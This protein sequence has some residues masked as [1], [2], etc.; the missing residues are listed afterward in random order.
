MIDKVD[1]LI[2][3]TMRRLDPAEHPYTDTDAR[4]AYAL[5]LHALVE[6]RAQLIGQPVVPPPPMPWELR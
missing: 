6:L 4:Q 5:Q 2:G 3:V 1:A